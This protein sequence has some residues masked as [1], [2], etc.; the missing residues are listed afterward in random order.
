MYNSDKT[1]VTAALQNAN[2]VVFSDTTISK[3]LA[4]TTTT[5]NST[6]V[7]DQ[8]TVSGSGAVTLGTGAEIALVS[9]SDTVQTTIVPPVSAPV[10]VFEG[11]GG[12]NVVIDDQAH[13]INHAAG[14][15]DRVVI[16]S[17]GADKIVLGDTENTL[18]VL[19]TG[20]SSVTAGQGH[21][22]VVGGKGNDT[23]IGG[24][25]GKTTVQLDGNS[26]DYSVKVAGSQVVVTDSKDGAVTTMSNVHYVQLDNGDALVMAKNTQEASVA[27]LYETVFGRAADKAG[28]E[29]WIN[30]AGPNASLTDIAKLFL[31]SSE[32]QA[33]HASGSG[34]D[35]QFV[36]NLYEQTFGR[37]AEAD[38][39]DYW[40]NAL[41]H[42]ATRADLV[43]DFASLATN[44]IA[45]TGET[46]TH[47]VGSVTIVGNIV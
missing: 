14:V 37:A 29:F 18:V 40:V 19:G 7:I 27:V 39:L 47:I 1:T 26:A 43:A 15:T 11:K 36:N 46:E 30:A 32:Y 42:G 5:T 28:L 31:N 6:V 12:V 33:Q 24:A 21:D 38:G 23:I 16:G 41:A 44:V 4:L 34:T 13:T 22:T 35:A 20:N 10:I 9:S 45:G 8:A 17:A 3:I 2:P 25:G